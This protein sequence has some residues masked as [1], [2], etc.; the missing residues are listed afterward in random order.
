VSKDLV[1]F[2]NPEFWQEAYDSF[3]KFWAVIHRAADALNDVTMKRV[4]ENVEPRQK[5]ILNLGLLS[6]V[7]V[8]ELITLVGN[9]FGLGAMKVARTLLESAIN[10]EYL[11]MFPEECEDYL[12]W[13]WVEQHKMLEYMREHMSVEFAQLGT[14]EIERTKDGFDKARHRYLRRDGSL[15]GSWCRLDLGARAAK[16]GFAAPY[17]LIYPMGSKLIHGTFGG[18]AMHFDVD[19]EESRIGMPPSPK[20]CAQALVGGHASLIRIVETVSKTFDVTPS[21][22]VQELLADYESAWRDS[23]LTSD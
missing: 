21:P 4:Y 6:A 10:A 13:H 5:V 9:G 22:S 1:Q 3:P 8:M 11:R 15:M 23:D 18:L 14:E 12:E 7:S 19:G 2:G 20:Y 16:V 17:K